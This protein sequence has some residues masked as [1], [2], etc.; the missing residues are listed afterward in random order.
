[1]NQIKGVIKS[2]NNSSLL[3][4][5]PTNRNS[6]R[7]P[8]RRNEDRQLEA[9]PAPMWSLCHLGWW[10]KKK[11]WEALGKPRKHR[12]IW[13][14]HPFQ[15]WKAQ[16][17]IQPKKIN[18]YPLNHHFQSDKCFGEHVNRQQLSFLKTVFSKN[19][20]PLNPLGHQNAVDFHLLK[21]QFW[22][23]TPPSSHPNIMSPSNASF[24]T[25]NLAIHLPISWWFKPS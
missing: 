2:T 6:D 24:H 11:L 22:G 15:N 1:M 5:H 13:E 9:T 19:T 17:W 3:N 16:D 18:G 21:R 25:S 20:V 4:I 8:W 10:R 7:A 12:G 23:V 14:V